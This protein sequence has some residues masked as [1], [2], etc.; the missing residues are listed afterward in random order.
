M[1][2]SP[3]C[4]ASR[5]RFHDYGAVEEDPAFVGD[6]VLAWRLER[7][8]QEG[9]IERRAGDWALTGKKRQR[10]LPRWLGGYEIGRASC[11]ERVFEAV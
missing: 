1:R 7:L 9:L 8:A 11:R 2:F 4:A 6:A 10:R 5:S 3:R